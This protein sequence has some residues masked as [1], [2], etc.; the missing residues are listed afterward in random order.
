MNAHLYSEM[1]L[2]ILFPNMFDS[3]FYKTIKMVLMGFYF[4]SPTVETVG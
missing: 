4:F 3:V 2:T 1:V